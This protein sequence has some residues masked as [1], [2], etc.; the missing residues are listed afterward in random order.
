MAIDQLRPLSLEMGAALWKGALKMGAGYLHLDGNKKML[1]QYQRY[2]ELDD[3]IF[4]KVMT[5]YYRDNHFALPGTAGAP[6][7][8]AIRIH[9]IHHVLAGYPTTPLGE[10]CVIAFD[11]ALMDDDLGKALIGYVAQF[12]VGLQFD[13]G[14][15]IWK[16]Q[17]DPDRVLRAFE[18]GGECT[19]NYLTLD[20][21]FTDLL[22][23]P[24][25][26]VR[27]RFNISPDGAIVRGSEVPWCGK[28]GVV[29]TRDGED[30]I[31][32]KSWLEKL[33]SGKN[34]IDETETGR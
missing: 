29:G 10:I 6:F 31:K 17:F 1:A 4:G 2:Q 27:E 26:A 11:A 16:N 3:G 23:E 22:E 18:R 33:L 19:V 21:D 30:M 5:D 25:D 12:Q 13:K 20:F 32:K 9:D 34:V 7:S 28:M 14:I 15:P 24:I 8:N